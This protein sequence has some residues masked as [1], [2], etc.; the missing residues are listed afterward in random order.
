MDDLPDGFTI[1]PAREADL[2]DVVELIEA[3]DRAL[4]LPVDP[5]RGE[6][7]WVWHLPTTQLDRDTRLVREGRLAVAY[8][9]ATW[10]VPE[11]GEP[12]DVVI[13][14]VPDRAETGIAERLLGWAEE[15]AE[16]RGSPGIRTFAADR[17]VALADVLRAHGFVHVRSMFTMWRE[18]GAEEDGGRPPE[19]V[20]IRP[21]SDADE[22]VLY[23]LHQAAFAEHWGF[24]P[25]SLE[26]WTE[27]LHGDGW[28]PS[29]VFLADADGAPAGYVIGFLE[30]TTG[31]VGMLGVLREQ[32][33]RGIA[34]ALLRRSFAE[35]ARLGRLDVRLG[36]D[37][38]NAAGAVRLY[39][40]VGMTARRRYD[41]FDLRTPEAEALGAV[42]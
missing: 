5:M 37:T 26:R 23:E 18:V 11:T 14:V 10:K 36:V 4:G 30:E 8:A 28:D 9:E 3:A 42:P 15:E 38:Q 29:L 2:D 17:D 40:G 25:V 21:Y 1:A 33:G 27:L 34:K 6:L 16:R 35:F 13:R 20:T 22:R 7:S 32:R 19:G 31:F 39:E 41:V 24:H 12:I